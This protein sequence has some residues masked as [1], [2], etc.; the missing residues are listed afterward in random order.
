MSIAPDDNAPRRWWQV[1]RGLAA[2]VGGALVLILA[3]LIAIPLAA[4]RAP[5]LAPETT[6]EGVVQ[7]F[8]AALYRGDYDAAHGFLSATTQRKVT[9]A[10]LQERLSGELRNSQIR[11]G[12]AK[13]T[14]DKASVRV[15]TTHFGSGD[16]FGSNEWNNDSEL[17]LQ[18][19]AAAWKIVSGFGYVPGLPGEGTR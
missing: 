19:E 7:R 5:A 18:R 2:L 12:A 16:L 13:I 1:D 10:Q 4:R 11:A 17:L 14:G 3:G 15:T 6:P 8:Y 9:P